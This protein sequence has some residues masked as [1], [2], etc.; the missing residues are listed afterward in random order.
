MPQVDCDGVLSYHLAH[1][2]SDQSP[3]APKYS[4]EPVVDHHTRLLVLGSL[5]G[6]R[7]LAVMQ[8]Y[9]HPQNAFW[10][11]MSAVTGTDL[12]A[13]S[14][15][16]RLRTLQ[17]HRIGLW[18]VVA[19]AQRAGSLDSAIRNHVGNDLPALLGHYPS[20]STIAFNGATAKKLGMKILADAAS[21]YRLFDLPSSSPAHTLP[22]DKKLGHWYA[23]RTVVHG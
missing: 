4:F 8:Y 1:M 6:E 5:P 23:L 19:Q 9:G 10:R 18:D 20:I 16:A 12:V 13:M 22:F 21:R 11:L 14:Y 2:D 7:S 15:Q 17:Q 3:P